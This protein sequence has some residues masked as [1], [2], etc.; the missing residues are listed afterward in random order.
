MD[1]IT[2]TI[3]YRILCE[4]INNTLKHAQ[5]DNI[6]IN[7][8]KVNDSL[9]VFY[10]DNGKGFDVEER[11]QDKKGIGLMSMQSRLKSINGQINFFSTQGK[12]TDIIIK[13]KINTGIFLENH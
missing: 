1:E 11:L 9:M 13:V 12:G 4:C 10:S 6:D 2:E 5:A 8:E 3:L 7:I